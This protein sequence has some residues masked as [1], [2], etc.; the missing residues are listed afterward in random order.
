M[1][2]VQ[3]HLRRDPESIAEAVLLYLA[4]TTIFISICFKRSAEINNVNKCFR[5]MLQPGK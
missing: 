4:G 5:K 1:E 2:I 3:G